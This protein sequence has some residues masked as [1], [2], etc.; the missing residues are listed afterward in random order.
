MAEPAGPTF[1]LIQDRA[2]PDK[3]TGLFYAVNKE[4]VAT[5]NRLTAADKAMATPYLSIWQVDPGTGKPAYPS[6]DEP[7]KPRGPLTMQTASPPNFGTSVA[8]YLNERPTVSLDKISIKTEANKGIIMFHQ[9]TMNIIVHRP[10]AF[11]SA[12]TPDKRD[13][14]DWSALIIPGN[15]FAVEYGW[16]NAPIKNDLFNGIGIEKNDIVIPGRRTLY[17]AITNYTFKIQPDMQIRIDITAYETGLLNLK[18]F[19]IGAA[20]TAIDKAKLD[21]KNI[22]FKFALPD[23]TANKNLYETTPGM[24]IKEDFTKEIQKLPSMVTLDQLLNNKLFLNTIVSAFKES[25]YDK[26]RL[27]YGKFN[28]RAGNESDKFGKT[29]CSDEAIGK[30]TIP[31]IVI[32]EIVTKNF[33]AGLGLTIH[34]FLL[35]FV[36]LCNDPRNWSADKSA[37][38]GDGDTP[39]QSIPDVFIKI[40]PNGSTIGM[41]I[42]DAKREFAGLTEEDS[43]KYVLSPTATRD[44]IAEKLSDVGVPIISFLNGN[45]YIKDANFSVEGDPKIKANFIQKYYGADKSKNKNQPGTKE[46]RKSLSA[47]ETLYSAAITG[48]ITTLGNFAFD[49]FSL[50]WLEFGIRRWDG[51]F[52]VRSRE[53]TITR[54]VFDTKIS[55]VAAGSDP[56]GTQGRRILK[57][58]AA[59]PGAKSEGK[60]D[61][62][63]GNTIVPEGN[64]NGAALKRSAGAR[65]PDEAPNTNPF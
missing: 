36:R 58:G 41:Y 3:G 65:D 22:E 25:G 60:K 64:I 55:F 31:K 2:N 54:G 24:K 23:R 47:E 1:S 33:K 56:L 53:D 49:S 16:S 42:V 40:V 34:N 57:P 39:I 45:S 26:I 9:L 48:D 28:K 7:N 12:P 10:D 63:T 18:K 11:Q 32:N 62:V 13:V 17:F 4:A 27:G 15:V 5:L 14:D 6:K 30:F 59:S 50:V 44:Q 8:G 19:I 46:K 51:P 61:S 38:K 52:N 29:K 43:K 35:P 21:G 20:P 37:K